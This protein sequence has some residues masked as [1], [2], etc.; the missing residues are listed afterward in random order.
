MRF[1]IVLFICC[2]TFFSHAQTPLLPDYFQF[3][4]ELDYDEN[5]PS[6]ADFLGYELGERF[7]VYAHS[8]DY[9]EELARVSDR[10][11]VSN[12]GETHEGRPLIYVVIT[13]TK[14][15]GNIETIQ[16]QNR[17]LWQ[18]NR[19]ELTEKSAT[20]PVVVSFSYNI[21]GNEAS[22]TETAMQFAYR[23]VA[24]QDETTEELL[25]NSVLLM[26]PCLNP[27]GRIRYTSWYSSV[28]R[29]VPAAAPIDLEHHAPWPNGRTNHYWFD[30]NRDWIWGVHPESRG[31]TNI[32]QEWMPQ[33]HT[34]FHEM[35]YNSNYFT[36]PGTTPRNLLLPD[37]YE[38]LS[39]TLGKANIAAFNKHKIN[40][41]TREA[42]DF[43][44]PGYGSS[45]PSVMGAIGMLV[46]QGGIGAGTIVET[47]DGNILTLRQ[48]IFDHYLTSLTTLEKAVANKD[49]FIRYTYEAQQ[50]AA[51]RSK[52][53]AYIFPNNDKDYTHD[54][55]KMLLRQG[56]TIHR[57]EE[58]FTLSNAQ[59]FTDNEPK[60]TA[61]KQGTYIVKTDQARHLF[62]NSIL[63]RNMAIE[64][65]VMYDMSTWSAPL[66]YNIEAYQTEIL[67]NLNLSE[68]EALPEAAKG[69]ST[70]KSPY[71]YVI[72]WNQRNAPRALAMLWEKGYN[73][74]SATEP[75]GTEEPL[76]SAGSLTVLAGRNRSKMEDMQQD[77]EEIAAT[78]EVEIIA[79]KSGRMNKGIDLASRRNRPLQQPKVALLIEPPFSTYTCGQI[80][81]LFDQETHLPVDRIRTSMLKQTA[82]PKFGSRYGY[83]DLN[84]Y[85]VL[86]L[87]GGGND[88]KK[89]FPDKQMRQLE[90]WI[91]NGGTL[92]ATE[93]AA[94]YFTKKNWQ[95]AVAQLLP[96]VKDSSEVAQYLP[97]AER[98]DYYGKKNVPGSAIL[99]TIDVTHPLAFG[100]KP[101]VYSLKFGSQALQPHP[102]LQTVG[103]YHQDAQK[104]LVAGYASQENLERIAGKTFAAVQ[105]FGSGK[106]VYLLDNTQYRMFW[107]GSARMMQNAVMLLPNF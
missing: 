8:V 79:L 24:A 59:S 42:F 82:M 98:R 40:Y 73:V 37:R 22:G 78:A 3:D 93:S 33:V 67:P 13:S 10:L 70:T 94:M 77:M 84:D 105:P 71:A 55:L 15:Q 47:N 56:V 92:V 52:V 17:E 68:V 27:D 12:Y 103:Y 49:D 69:V 48:R 30:L 89:L 64:D 35:G 1:F 76:Y 11:T 101:E 97:Y 32:Y 25:D 104:N 61:F 14:N 100:M 21:H 63:G 60:R 62:I 86:I 87:A 65:S 34:D 19:S 39:D 44:Y 81:Y 91:A 95:K 46:E 99:S 2:S 9:F 18:L 88:L 83:A 4:P 53:Q 58:D 16:Q 51:N 106:V 57:S 6:P 20:Q 75:F 31:H 107:L 36:M 7:T 90:N 41:F 45:Y 43:F 74:R 29:N 80:Y 5:I 50:P 102:N 72:D 54:M 28:Q 85:D 66:A 23:L 96:N 38:A 26:F